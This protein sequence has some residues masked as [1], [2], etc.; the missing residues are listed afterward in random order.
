MDETGV[1]LEPKPPKVI[2]R[3]GQKK[4]HYRTSGQKAQIT[5]IGCGN[6]VGNILPPFIIIAVKQLNPLWTRSEVSGT[7][8]GVS[9]KGWVDQELFFHWLKEHFFGQCCSSTTTSPLTR[10]TQ[11]PF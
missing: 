9:D 11:L 1:P 3:K 10:W 7:R 8:Y 5:V 4:I 2:A 6:A